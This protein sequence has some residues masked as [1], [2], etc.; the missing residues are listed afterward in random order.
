M[1]KK[2]ARKNTA[3]M[4]KIVN[5]KKKSA[6]YSL[7][8]QNIETC[9]LLHPE[10]QNFHFG[11]YGCCWKNMSDGLSAGVQQVSMLSN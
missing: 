1:C 3:K 6:V 10:D 4:C 7:T 2:N 5:A 11:E 8:R 9:V